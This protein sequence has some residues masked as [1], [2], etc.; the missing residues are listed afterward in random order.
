[1][2]GWLRLD[3]APM[4]D[5]AKLP[6]GRRSRKRAKTPEHRVTSSTASPLSYRHCAP[7]VSTRDDRR[8]TAEVRATLGSSKSAEFEARSMCRVGSNFLR[9]LTM[10]IAFADQLAAD[11]LKAALMPGQARWGRHA[12]AAPLRGAAPSEVRA[13]EHQ[14]T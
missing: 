14:R 12:T 3:P 1:M 7:A 4:P 13:P 11:P 6:D 9:Q 10:K 8:A 5:E 2:T